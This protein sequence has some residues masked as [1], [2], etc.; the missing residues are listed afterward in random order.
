ML[1]FRPSWERADP[2]LN[3]SLMRLTVAWWGASENV[4]TVTCSISHGWNRSRAFP[5]TTRFPRC[6][7]ASSLYP[8]QRFTTLLLL[9]H[10]GSVWLLPFYYCCK[11]FKFRL[12]EMT[13][14]DVDISTVGLRRMAA[15]TR[16]QGVK[17]MT[18]NFRI[19]SLPQQTYWHYDGEFIT[20]PTAQ[21]N[22]SFSD[23]FGIT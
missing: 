13:K 18:N 21:S 4:N 2:V 10:K 5:L 6:P 12:G 22:T 19:L 11:T 16:G 8:S 1:N 23:A 9:K 7:L 15:G 20:R 17:V 14:N 3:L